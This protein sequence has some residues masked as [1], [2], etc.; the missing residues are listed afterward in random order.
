MLEN[1]KGKI[2][3]FGSLIHGSG[4]TFLK[5]KFYELVKDKMEVLNISV[6]K[7]FREMASEKGL[8]IEEFIKEIERNPLLDYEIDKKI[9]NLIKENKDKYDLILIDSNL[10]PY[11]L[12]FPNV[13]KILV[14]ADLDIIAK[15]VFEKRRK[16]DKEY[17]SIEEAKKDL[18]ERTRKD[19][20]RYQKLAKLIDN[21]FWKKV[22]S[23]YGDPT[24]FDIVIDNSFDIE[25]VLRNLIEK[26][27]RIL[28]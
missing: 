3:V 26:L 20:E 21:P 4:R 23:S 28:K 2:L 18:I 5:N 7:I 6:G 12:N 15:R 19:K 27:N 9:Y 17:K 13:I 16:G 8:T 22:Y 25:I 24:V 14:V 1:L 10:A 11:Y